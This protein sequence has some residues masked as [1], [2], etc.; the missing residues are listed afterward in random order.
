M[1]APE[2]R[3]L[4]KRTHAHVF[5]VLVCVALIL[6]SADSLH[7]QGNAP[8]K[9]N[10]YHIGGTYL[11]NFAS[12]AVSVVTSPIKWE[13]KDFTTLAVILGTGAVLMC[14]DKDIYAWSERQKTQSSADAAL[15]LSDMGD[16][17]T[18]LGLMGAMYL[19]GELFKNKSLRKTALLCLE[20]SII[21][22]VLVLG[23]KGVTGRSR[24]HSAEGKG[25]F[26]PFSGNTSFPSGHSQTAFSL[27]SVIAE[28]SDSIFVDSLC[29]GTAA[30]IAASRVHK[31]SH[32]ASDILIG[33]AIGYFIGKKIC[34]L[35][36]ERDNLPN[37]SFGLN[38]SPG[39]Q[40]I[41]VRFSF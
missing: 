39:F 3:M 22:G 31:G 1:K 40:G 38:V 41:S 8:P 32:W 23:L 36:R 27:A 26:D 33:S 24:P 10:R 11:K 4:R 13:K 19:S 37:V 34:S 7:G 30:S 28:Q 16:V 20:S 6:F 5:S 25:T 21:S 17:G 29:Y 2:M 14:F 35:N 12:D 9:E 15:F 18:A